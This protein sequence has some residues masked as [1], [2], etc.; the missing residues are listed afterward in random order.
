MCPFPEIE[1]ISL[2][3]NGSTSMGN[4]SVKSQPILK[5]DMRSGTAEL[6]SETLRNSDQKRE[7]LYFLVITS[8]R[9]EVPFQST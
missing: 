6:Q 4:I 5:N 7:L 3:K 9:G 1:K 2:M 8:W